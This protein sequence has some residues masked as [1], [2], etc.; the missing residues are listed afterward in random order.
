MSDKQ[1]ERIQKLVENPNL[2][3][4]EKNFITSVN[5]YFQ[6]HGRVSNK[7]WST[8]QKI[9]ANHSPE[10]I[11][12]RQQWNDNFSDDMRQMWEM[13]MN[14]YEKNPPYYQDLVSKYRLSPEMIPTAKLYSKIVENN[15][16]IQKVIKN[17]ISEPLYEVGSLVQ[18]RKTAKG[19]HYKF[20]NCIAMVVD[21]NG[22]VTSAVN[23]AKT[24]SI[25]PFGESAPIK[26]QERWLKKKRGGK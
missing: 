16:Y 2:N 21:N 23:G 26:I 13:A 8:I 20:R 17:T 10:V 5:S 3:N 14:Y 19:S 9:E 22:P 1:A 7:Q 11:A 25:L 6:R 24:Y 15:K 12:Q 18:V 4:W